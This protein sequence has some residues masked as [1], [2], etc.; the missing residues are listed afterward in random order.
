MTTDIWLLAS[1]GTTIHA[2]TGVSAHLDRPDA[3]CG[4]RGLSRVRTQRRR[5]EGKPMNP[6]RKC[7]T[8]VKART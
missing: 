1:N 2:P 8:L 3:V 4:R 5:E 7:V 6:C